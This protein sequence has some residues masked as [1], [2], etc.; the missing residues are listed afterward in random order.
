LDI[1]VHIEAAQNPE[2][3]TGISRFGFEATKPPE[4]SI[5]HESGLLKGKKSGKST[6]K[7]TGLLSLK[8]HGFGPK[9][10]C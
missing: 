9:V 10:T 5:H 4:Q 7:G 3:R 8:S 6:A 1:V 2:A